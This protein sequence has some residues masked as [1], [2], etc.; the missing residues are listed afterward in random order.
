MGPTMRIRGTVAALVVCGAVAI[1]PGAAQADE[2]RDCGLGDAVSVTGPTWPAGA[3]GSARLLVRA[4]ASDG[5]AVV[6]LDTQVSSPDGGS[7]GDS[8]R[9]ASGAGSAWTQHDVRPGATYRLDVLGT[10]GLHG[11]GQAFTVVVPAGPPAPPPPPP[12]PGPAT[13]TW[14]F[15]SAANLPG[16]A[17]R[18]L[19]CPGLAGWDVPQWPEMRNGQTRVVRPEDYGV[20]PRP[21]SSG[22]HVLRASVDQRQRDDGAYAAYLYKVWATGAPETGWSSDL[23]NRPLERMRSGQEA[24]SYRAWYFLPESTRL[25]LQHN[26]D[27]GH[28][29]V[30]IF[31]FKHSGPNLNGPG[32]WDQPP[33]WWVNIRNNDPE[34]LTLAVSRWRDPAYGVRRGNTPAVP[35]GRWFEL[36]ADVFPGNRIDF[37]LD[38]RQF[39]TAHAR[40]HPV[41]LGP[42]DS[43]WV[44]SPGWYLNTGT[45][46]IDD[47]TFLRPGA[48]AAR[49]RAARRR[50]R[51]RCPH[52]RTRRSRCPRRHAPTRR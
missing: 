37:Y 35:F 23:T 5:G 38:G 16:C 30:N 48:I 29:W 10:F 15:E 12:G 28:G 1:A 14:N 44:F 22:D 45:A 51:R 43:S 21:G 34:R 47:V 3:G 42:G 46:Y 26:N 20:P 39:E 4:T 18:G 8:H 32:R 19:S 17:A 41:G 40:E 50:A 25:T 7:T 2:T 13:Y 24:G 52:R 31:Q 6:L 27:A 33:E 9:A 49:K 36:R 11:C